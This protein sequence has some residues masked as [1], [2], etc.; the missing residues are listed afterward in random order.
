MP[1]ASFTRF[2]AASGLTNLADGIA[3]VAWAWMASL[4]TRDPFLVA[5]M[6]VALRLPWFL[7]A[8]PAG[9]VTDRVD[10]RKLILAMDILRAIAFTIATIVIWQALPLAAPP[11]SGLAQPAV[12]YTLMATAMLVGGAE[13]FRDNAAQ[14]M[15][16]SLVDHNVLERANGQLWSVELIG[17]SLVGPALGAFLIAV[18]APA[19]F[20]LNGLAYAVA[21]VCVMSLK[22]NF[23]PASM[24]IKPNWK[25]ELKEAFNFLKSSPL[26]RS[27]ALITGGWN[28]VFQMSAIAL[29]LH[30][31]E[32]LN[33]GATAYG[34]L[35]AAGAFGGISAGF[36]A[37]RI[38]KR[39][40]PK[41]TAQVS[42]MMSAPSFLLMAVAP[43]WLTLATTIAVF[44]FAGL[45]WN[46]VSVSYRQRKIPDALLG[47]VNSLYR[48]LA[49]GLMP[50]GLI[51]S[52][53]IVRYAEPIIGRSDALSLPIFTASLGALV[54]GFIGWMALE[55]GFSHADQDQPVQPL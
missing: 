18:F 14:T 51:L 33:L 3:T 41:R 36:L 20:A 8:I 11:S 42:L 6:P 38:I 54:L 44:E 52:G 13:V 17:N 55:R 35:L 47:R 26:L 12:F 31:Q 30:V 39:F 1:N 28:L 15:L 19:P 29:V 5:L 23:K 50:I 25:N 9:I 46:T 43:N 21:L 7:F 49:W 10:R 34:L 2:V 53:L 32:N 48:L 16:P 22:G 24:N 27:L 40:G 4:L 45:T 37:E